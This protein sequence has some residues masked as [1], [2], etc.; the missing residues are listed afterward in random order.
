MATS[1]LVT[2]LRAVCPSCRQNMVYAAI[3]IDG[4]PVWVWICNCRN[5][6]DNISADV[7]NARLD[8]FSSLVYEVEVIRGKSQEP[9]QSGD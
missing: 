3:I 9:A 4:A 6:P 7:E 2:P 8:P 1:S 5:Q